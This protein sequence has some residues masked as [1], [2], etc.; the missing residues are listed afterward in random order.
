MT[1]T[2]QAY[3]H[4]R[5]SQSGRDSRVQRQKQTQP[6]P[7]NIPNEI[8]H[9]I[10]SRLS[11]C[12]L[13]LARRVNRLF[14]FICLEHIY[15]KYV[16][17][18]WI[19]IQLDGVHRHAPF[20][21]GMPEK[22]FFKPEED[23]Q[24]LKWS[25]QSSEELMCLR[26]CTRGDIMFIVGKTNTKL[27]IFLQR[28]KKDGKFVWDIGPDIERYNIPERRHY[29]NKKKYP[30]IKHDDDVPRAVLTYCPESRVWEVCL[31]FCRLM[32]ILN[33]AYER[34]VSMKYSS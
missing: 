15:N 23:G 2:L 17:N 34:Y 27:P 26:R 32:A 14:R 3:S 20:S 7:V 13:L 5:Y 24:M 31:P 11:L 1:P 8:L 6:I 29:F 21:N 19:K 28:A 33:K 22:L 16:R 9:D 10:L 12:D 4:R 30:M 18:S 25:G